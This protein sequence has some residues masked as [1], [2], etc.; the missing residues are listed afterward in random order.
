MFRL[1][2]WAVDISVLQIAQTDSEIQSF[3]FS[4]YRGIFPVLR[5]PECEYNQLPPS[6]AEISMSGAIPP[7]RNI[8]SWR[9]YLK[10]LPQNFKLSK[11]KLCP[12][13]VGLV[14]VFVS[15]SISYFAYTALSK[16]W[17]FAP[18]ICCNVLP[19]Y[20]HGAF[21][22]F[23]CGYQNKSR[24]FPYTALIDRVL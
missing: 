20:P 1:Q 2:A 22:C 13:N 12:E 23:L 19:F 15:F 6:S 9:S 7:L 11:S 3:L 16:A 8:T 4:C 17:W 24:L 21:M 18:G 14:V 5:R 10:T